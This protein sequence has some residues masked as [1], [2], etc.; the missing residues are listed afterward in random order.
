MT[1][2][3][4]RY[5]DGQLGRDALA[6]SEQTDAD[7]A[8]RAIADTR[9]FLAERAAPDATDR[10]MRGLLDH[11][12]HVVPTSR[13]GWFDRLVQRLWTP[14]QV[15]VRPAYALLAAGACAALLV[16]VAPDVWLTRAVA[17]QVADRADARRSEDSASALQ[18]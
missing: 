16:F 13:A 15:S 2:R 18:S 17:P 5:L 6:D 12:A 4:D 14:R 10:V 1:D 3:I 9:A 8:A 7:A 11:L